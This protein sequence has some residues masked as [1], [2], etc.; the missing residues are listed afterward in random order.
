MTIDLSGYET[1]LLR[2]DGGILTIT[3]NRPGLRNATNNL[4]ERDC[5]ACSPTPITIRMSAYS[6]SRARARPSARGGD[7]EY[8]RQNQA[9]PSKSWDAGLRGKQI[10]FTLLDC[11][12]PIVAKING[13][14]IGFGATLALFCDALLRPI[15]PRSVIRMSR[16]AWLRATVDR[17]IWPQLV[18]YGRA[19]STYS[20]AS[21]CSRRRRAHR[22]DQSR[23]ARRGA[24]PGGRGFCI[25]AGS[26]PARALQWTKASVNIGLKQLAHSIMDA[27]IAYELLSITT[28]DHGEAMTALRE[29]A[30]QVH[31]QVEGVRRPA[32]AF[33]AR[34]R[35]ARFP[36][37]AR[38]RCVAPKRAK[39]HMRLGQPDLRPNGLARVDGTREARAEAA[40][41]AGI[42]RRGCPQHGTAYDAEG[43]GSVQNRLFESGGLAHLRVD[44]QRIEVTRQSID[45]RLLRPGGSST[46]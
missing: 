30:A 42:I 31:R 37:R 9:E 4:M 14:A 35:F 25:E 1:L 34:L 16:S 24:R 13:H 7:F 46:T 40:Q 26:M 45:E 32:G 2:E 41:T 3:L 23:H 38:R 28:A 10:I 17:S 27:S 29:S 11:V 44:M 33:S 36:G 12:K 20:P 21:H 22:T 18:G 15:M 43:A 6:S 39:S 8:I 5:A 19:R